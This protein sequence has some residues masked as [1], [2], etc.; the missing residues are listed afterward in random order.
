MGKLINKTQG[1]TI[2]SSNILR[3]ENLSIRDRGLLCTLFSLPDNW[4]FSIKGL[5][6]ILPDG[7]DTIRASLQ[8]LEKLGYLKRVQVKDSI[9]RFSGYD[10]Q[11]SET[12]SPETSE[13]EISEPETSEPEI[14]RLKLLQMSLNLPRLQYR[15]SHHQKSCLQRKR[16]QKNHRQEM[17][18]PPLRCQKNRRRKTRRR[19]SRRRKCRHN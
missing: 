4:E 6:K 18:Y 9:G 17:T 3:D 16:H 7:K 15:K 14:L 11:L 8:R 19:E 12:P 2:I 13:P 10:Y 5:T 1:F